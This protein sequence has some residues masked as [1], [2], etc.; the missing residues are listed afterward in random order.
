[1]FDV[2][3]DHVIR[4]NLESLQQGH[5]KD[6]QHG[7]AAIVELNS[8][9]IDAGLDREAS[10]LLKQSRHLIKKLSEEEMSH[11]L[12]RLRQGLD[13]QGEM[14]ARRQMVL[15]LEELVLLYRRMVLDIVR[16]EL[17]EPEE[18]SFTHLA[19]DTLD[20]IKSIYDLA[21]GSSG[22]EREQK[23]QILALLRRSMDIIKIRCGKDGDILCK[24]CQEILQSVKSKPA[25]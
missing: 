22:L 25:P 18:E 1:V 7:M 19:L 3:I 15:T 16:F 12:M 14:M 8:V 11:H 9:F 5:A 4:F 24:R 23:A 10:Q 2:V 6:L 17:E 20:S 13:M 21:Q